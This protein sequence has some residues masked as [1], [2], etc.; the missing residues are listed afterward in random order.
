M[1]EKH[2][3]ARVRFL[4]EC[5]KSLGLRSGGSAR[6]VMDDGGGESSILSTTVFSL[7]RQTSAAN[8]IKVKE[9]GKFLWD[10][11]TSRVHFFAQKGLRWVGSLVVV[12]A[13]IISRVLWTV[14]GLIRHWLH[15]YRLFKCFKLQ[16]WGRSVRAAEES[17]L[18]WAYWKQG[19][20]VWNTHGF[21]GRV[22]LTQKRNK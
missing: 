12:S 9:W 13:D 18:D 20:K 6:E 14:G 17:N 1:S 8:N 7:R 5:V 16:L 15:W 11:R 10:G 2:W 22:A 4:F 3:R 21:R 19:G